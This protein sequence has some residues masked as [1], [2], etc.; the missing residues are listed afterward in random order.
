VSTNVADFLTQ[1]NVIFVFTIVLTILTLVI[2][3]R[4]LFATSKDDKEVKKIKIK[5]GI[6]K[7]ERKKKLGLDT[8]RMPLYFD[9]E[10][11]DQLNA[12]YKIKQSPYELKEIKLTKG[13]EVNSTINTPISSLGSKQNVAQ[14]VYLEPNSHQELT[15]VTMLNWLSDED[16]LINE[17][18]ESDQLNKLVAVLEEYFFT[19]PLIK[20]RISSI[21]KEYSDI[22][23]EVLQS[24]D[25]LIAKK[26]QTT[27]GKFVYLRGNF[28]ITQSNHKIF[29]IQREGL[30]DFAATGTLNKCTDTGKD[31]FSAKGHLKASV[32]GYISENSNKAPI[33]VTPIAI[34]Q[35]IG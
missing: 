12:Q 27:K 11:L 5:E 7:K 33:M 21:P 26:I 25:D 31:V 23:S 34:H 6:A 32:F 22:I 3:I 4:N 15:Y 14:E 20:E 18:E 29:L 24:K 28:I 16:L 35:L 17:G 9:D 13:V 8:L 1:S 10:K 30:A 2:T 19:D